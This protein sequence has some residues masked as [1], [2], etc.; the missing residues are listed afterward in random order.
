MELAIL[1]RYL[2]NRL[3]ISGCEEEDRKDPPKSIPINIS[4]DPLDKY[5]NR[6]ANSIFNQTLTEQIKAEEKKLKQ[7][8]KELQ[9]LEKQKENLK[10]DIEEFKEKILKAESEIDVNVKAQVETRKSI[11]E[12]SKVLETIKNKQRN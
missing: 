10:T 11:E 5:L 8:E 9:K 6:I 2:S 1:L 12:Q 3:L 7:L 4:S